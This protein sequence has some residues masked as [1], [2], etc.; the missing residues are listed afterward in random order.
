MCIQEYK[1]RHFYTYIYYKYKEYICA[2]YVINI[3]KMC[4]SFFLVYSLLFLFLYIFFFNLNKLYKYA[5]K[6]KIVI[7]FFCWLPFFL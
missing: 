3:L 2:I 6:A 7:L 4:I 1:Y 5:E